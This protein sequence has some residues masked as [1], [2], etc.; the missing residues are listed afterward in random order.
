MLD[1]RT[2]LIQCEPVAHACPEALCTFYASDTG[3]KFGTE[4]AGV[5]RFVRKP[6]DSGKPDVDRR[7]SEAFLLQ[8]EAVPENDRSIERESRF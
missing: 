4:E 7:R 2:C 6:P 1:K 8:K 5:R 3:C